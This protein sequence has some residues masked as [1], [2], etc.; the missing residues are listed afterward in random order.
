MTTVLLLIV[1]LVAAGL[2]AETLREAFH[3]GPG[4][5]GPP[6]SHQE[7]QRFQPPASRAA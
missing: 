6:R 5:Q 4:T 1:A 2:V 3:D 7:D